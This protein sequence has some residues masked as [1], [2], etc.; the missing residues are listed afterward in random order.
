MVIFQTCIC[1]DLNKFK[2]RA[3]KYASSVW[4]PAYLQEVERKL[5]YLVKHHLD[6]A[7]FRENR[8]L[9]Q[10]Y[11]DFRFI[12]SSVIK[13]QKIRQDLSIPFFC[14]PI[15]FIIIRFLQFIQTFCLISFLLHL[16][17]FLHFLQI[18]FTL[19]FAQS[20]PKY[21]VAIF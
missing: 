16:S 9:I 17:F 8:Y 12:Y 14:N 6:L 15:Y 5:F 10:Q 7:R 18:I 21:P 11:Q 3:Q 2:H 1:R 13:S 19:F 20:T 4:N